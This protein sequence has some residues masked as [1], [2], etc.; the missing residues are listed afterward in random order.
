M[1]ELFD[2]N[3]E[4]AIDRVGVTAY[5]MQEVARRQLIGSIVAGMLVA[6]VAGLVALHPSPPEMALSSTHTISL[7]RHPAVMATFSHDLAAET[8][9]R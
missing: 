6:S 3:D 1:H 4:G 8:T 7:I 9:D 2:S 5:E